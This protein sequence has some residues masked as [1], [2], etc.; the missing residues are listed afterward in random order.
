MLLNSLNEVVPTPQAANFAIR[1]LIGRLGKVL[2]KSMSS[3]AVVLL[4]SRFGFHSSLK[5]RRLIKAC[6]GEKCCL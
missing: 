1:R 3:A 5:C 2:D 6:W 4:N